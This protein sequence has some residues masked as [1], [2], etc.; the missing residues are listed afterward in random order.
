MGG[1][2][3]EA[4]PFAG[5]EPGPHE[6]A[7]A[8]EL[9]RLVLNAVNSLSPRNR[10]ATL[11][12]YYDQLS[13]REVAATL[14]ISVTA[15]KG[16]LYASRAS[17]REMLIHVYAGLERSPQEERKKEKIMLKVEIVDI[18]AQTREDKDTGASR[19]HHVAVLMDAEG[20]RILPI[21]VGKAEGTAI[22]MG[23]SDAEL[24]R[25]LTFTFMSGLLEASGV[26]VE[27]VRVEK[28]A[29][30]TFYAVAKVRNGEVVREVDARPSDAMALA[31]HTG[32]PIYVAEE[33][34]KKAGMDVPADVKDFRSR[35]RGSESV[36]RRF[37]ERVSEWH[38]EAKREDPKKR[39][40]VK[41]ARQELLA[42]IF[43]GEGE[44]PGEAAG[45]E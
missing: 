23:L 17:L 6:V 1:V 10:A 27:E 30:D 2:R 31:L 7:E 16:R 14:S 5:I 11:L 3:F 25:P 21:W 28:L 13:V 35:T 41:N 24:P 26:K 45:A 36:L 38:Q 42:S 44:E 34:M 8:R 43:G 29:S 18:V 9:H 33:V 32:S 15:V 4:I 40:E 37:E 39:Q 19:T 12:F 22:T 20:R